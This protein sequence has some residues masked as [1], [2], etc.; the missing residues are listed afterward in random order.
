MNIDQKTY[1]LLIRSLDEKLPE[2]QAK[3]LE[4]ALAGS[5]ELRL[6][7][8]KLRKM[9]NLMGAFSVNTAPDF[10]EQLMAKLPRKSSAKIISL[11][12]YATSIAAA[13]V[14]LV[15]VSILSIYAWEGNLSTEA[16]LGIQDLSP[17][18]AYTIL[19]Y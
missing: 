15:L 3:Q 1:D 5:A 17:E 7:Q 2:A 12:R 8:Q 14:L 4:T 11:K 19:N 6:E 10:S 16:L 13:C 9:R 18:D